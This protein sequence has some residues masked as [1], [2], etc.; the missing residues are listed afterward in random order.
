MLPALWFVAR[1]LGAV[2]LFGWIAAVLGARLLRGLPSIS[3]A[4]TSRAE[5]LGVRG[6]VGLVALG[7]GGF[8][9]GLAGRLTAGAAALLLAA[10][11]SW[12][13][14]ESVE[15]WRDLAS[16]VR[17]SSKRHRRAV[18][19]AVGVFGVVLVP[20]LALSLFPPTG[21]DALNYHLPYVRA[22]VEHGSLVPVDTVRFPVFPQLN[23][24]LF[25]LLALLVD[26]VAAQGVQ[27]LPTLWIA[28]LLASWASRIGGR[29][30]GA[31]AAGLWLGNPIVVWMA[32][33]AYID[34]G[35][36][37]FSVAGFVCLE[38][39]RLDR[40]KSFLWLGGALLGAACSVKYL[41]MFALALG[42]VHAC[43]SAPPGRRAR[44]AIAVL[45]AAAAIAAPWYARIAWETGNPVFPYLREVFGGVDWW[46]VG[47]T[48]PNGIP[49]A[50]RGERPPI[51][52]RLL[53][54]VRLGPEWL[55][56]LPVTVTWA[57]EM[58]GRQA[59]HTPWT[60]LVVVAMAWR[61][62]RD[63]RLLWLLL[64][65]AVYALLLLFTTTR[66]LR[67][68]LP[69]AA[70]LAAGG[71]VALRPAVAAGAQLWRRLRRRRAGS[72]FLAHRRVVDCAIVLAFLGPG[73]VYGWYKLTE[74]GPVPI[75]AAARDEHLAR[76]VPAYSAVAFLNASH[77]GGY[78]VYGLPFEPVRYYARGRYLGDK[79]GTYGYGQ[80]RRRLR[81]GEPLHGLL[82]GWGAEYVLIEAPGRAAATRWGS[83]FVPVYRDQEAWVMR[84]A[85]ESEGC[86]EPYR[87]HR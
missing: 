52:D 51:W 5:A 53:S 80:V 19:L 10:S 70:A 43:G 68:L 79:Y 87:S 6:S 84:V 74:R 36:T 67:F 62:R 15:L 77:P 75:D 81:S 37:L 42:I 39:F 32:G 23:E 76:W 8:V 86:S 2:L 44:H 11:A 3:R 85:A 64:G 7:T 55:L 83:C 59:P 33:Q 20:M 63:R 47:S 26:D 69:V 58:F 60:L 4:F 82:R 40:E 38:R 22:F 78:T 65:C 50:D 21:Y 73:V 46:H 72:R 56:T 29:S 35:L 34:L 57:R 25:T 48:D 31:W 16:A 27:L 30:S 18:L 54:V 45:L 61:A 12:S 41:G 17:A 71:A 24:V 66:D 1:H 28:L 13:W 9:L 14:R 49:L